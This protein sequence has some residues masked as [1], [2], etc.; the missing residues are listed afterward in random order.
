MS[1][2]EKLAY[3]KHRDKLTTEEVAFRAKQPVGTLNKVFSGQTKSPAWETM[4]AVCKVFGVPIR[5]VLDDSIPMEFNASAYAEH[6]GM[7]L[8]SPEERNLLL[9]ARQLAPQDQRCVEDLIRQY[10]IRLPKPSEVPCERL[11]PCYEPLFQVQQGFFIDSWRNW[12]LATPVDRTTRNADCAVVVIND[13]LQPVYEAGDVLAVRHWV[14][15]DNR[16]GIFLYNG[17]GHIRTL[18]RKRDEVRLVSVK[19]GIRDICVGAKDELRVFGE[20]LGAIRNYRRI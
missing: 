13:E 11:I 16:L 10:I 8:I 1:M 6:T 5:Y 19:S 7:L 18:Y 3:L 2:A 15:D 17:E 4:N 9:D 12:T 20:V 14:C